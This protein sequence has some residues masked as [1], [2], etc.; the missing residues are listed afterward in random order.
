MKWDISVYLAWQKEIIF[1]NMLTIYSQQQEENMTSNGM[2]SDPVA[3]LPFLK[4]H[5]LNEYSVL[6]NMHIT[7]Y[8]IWQHKD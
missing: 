7:G 8:K 5:R 4:K 3:G 2:T 6:K 1:K